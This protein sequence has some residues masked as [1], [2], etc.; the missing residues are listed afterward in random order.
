M[1]SLRGKGKEREKEKGKH[2]S[3]S[4]EI[5]LAGVISVELK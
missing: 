2:S 5:L 4:V 3:Q 1:I